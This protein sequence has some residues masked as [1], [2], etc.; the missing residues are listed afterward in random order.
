[1]WTVNRINKWWWQHYI[2]ISSHS[3]GREQWSSG[4]IIAYGAS[5]PGFRASA[6]YIILK[7]YFK[8]LKGD[9]KSHNTFNSST[10]CAATIAHLAKHQL[11]PGSIQAA[12]RQHPAIIQPASSQH[13]QWHSIE[14]H[15]R[16]YLWFLSE[17]DSSNNCG[18]VVQNQWLRLRKG[19]KDILKNSQ[20]SGRLETR[21]QRRHNYS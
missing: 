6:R 11:H 9:A 17:T 16:T 8:W 3:T 14:K 7:S 5:G 12:S 2:I 13:Q 1:M 20:S 15:W 10:K 4:Y 19:V 18:Y 21:I